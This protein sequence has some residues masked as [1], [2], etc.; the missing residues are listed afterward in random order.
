MP[1]ELA[2]SHTEVFYEFW[3]YTAENYSMFEVKQLDWDAIYGIYA[4]QINDQLSDEQFFEVMSRM[5]NE[6]KM[7]IATY[8]RHMAL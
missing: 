1:D 5:M 3:T 7:G 2:Q 8:T 4:P 6:L